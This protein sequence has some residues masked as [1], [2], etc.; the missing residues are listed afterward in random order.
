MCC[1]NIILIDTNFSDRFK[2]T[3]T[4]NTAIATIT[5]TATITTNTTI[6]TI[7]IASIINS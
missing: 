2:N 7:I 6:T 4:T 5:T 1:P 3:A